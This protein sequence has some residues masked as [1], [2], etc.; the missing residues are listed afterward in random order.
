[1]AD[2]SK[3]K[4]IWDS[5]QPS[6]LGRN[7]SRTVGDAVSSRTAKDDHPSSKSS[8]DPS[9]NSASESSSHYNGGTTNSSSGGSSKEILSSKSN[10][11][12]PNAR[13]K[14][15]QRRPSTLFNTQPTH[16]PDEE[17]DENDF[18]RARALYDYNSREQDEISFKAG[19]TVFIF[20][21]HES[22]W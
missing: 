3:L 5:I 18:I 19:Q 12:S 7:R 8:N 14:H 11:T 10:T 15:L 13:S 6:N 22:G 9:H 20:H 4:K 2:D 16:G 1:M 21:K 17:V